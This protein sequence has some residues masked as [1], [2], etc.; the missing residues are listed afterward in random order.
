MVVFSFY[1]AQAVRGDWSGIGAFVAERGEGI[2][3]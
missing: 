3:T 2:E 1:S